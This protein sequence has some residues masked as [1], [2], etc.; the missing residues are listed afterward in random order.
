M[1]QKMTEKPKTKLPKFVMSRALITEM[2][3]YAVQIQKGHCNFTSVHAI[4]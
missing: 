1:Q 3:K 2:R 4:M